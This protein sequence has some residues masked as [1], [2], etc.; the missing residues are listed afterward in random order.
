MTD[1]MPRPRAAKLKSRDAGPIAGRDF[2][3][4]VGIAVLTPIAWLVPP[5]L[6]HRLS[7]SMAAIA[8]VIGLADTRGLRRRLESYFG[9]QAPKPAS[10]IAASAL[11][12]YV[13]STLQV[14]RAHRPG[15]WHPAVDLAGAEHVHA[16]LERGHGAIL[17]I[18]FFQYYTL[19]SK[20]APH[21]A[22]FQVSH[23]S[24]PRHGFSSSR[25]GV[26]VLNRLYTA[27]EDRYLRERVRLSIES[28][29]PAMRA[30][31]R[32][33]ETNGVVSITARE[34]ASQPA[35]VPF[36]S[37][38]MLVATGAPDLAFRTGAALLPVHTV[39]GEDGRFRVVIEPS[40]AP[41]E[42]DRDRRA[43]SEAAA[44]AYAERL[45]GWVRRY[46]DQWRGWFHLG[47]D[48]AAERG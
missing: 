11:G 34:A 9:G 18:S 36:L 46:P 4:M 35:V 41:A 48:D 7:T 2:L 5:S 8:G 23:L 38:V 27:I 25:F 17:W 15:A 3:V 16:A 32:R 19:I 20:I 21:R 1:A 42:R 24:H 31:T 13:D 12:Y 22:G 47:S 10:G 6:W 45:E 30:L 43:F 39:L 37:G 29:L 44:R 14:L 33:L 26:R 40:I 28:P